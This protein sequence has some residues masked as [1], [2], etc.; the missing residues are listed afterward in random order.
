MAEKG[1][2][3][4]YRDRL[5]KTLSC[6]DLVSKEVLKR[7]VR[8]QILSSSS[9][10]TPQ[11]FIDNVVERRSNELVHTLGMLRSA[12]LAEGGDSNPSNVSHGG[13]K[14]KQDAEELRVMYREGPEGTPFHIL[15]VEGFVDGPVDV[16]LCISW[17][18]DLYKK[19]WPQTTVPNFKVAYSKCL[20]KV[21]IGEHISVVRMKLPWPL[22]TREALINFFEF[23]YFQDGLVVV[24]F[25]S[26][27]DIE[28][29]G[30]YGSHGL[31]RD[32]GLDA[33]DDVVRIDVVG[34]FA[35]QKVTAN[36]SYFRTIANMDIKLDFVPPT[37]I[38]FFSRQLIGSGFKLY[39]KEVASVSRGDEDFSNALKDPMYNRIREALY[40]HDKSNGHKNNYNQTNVTNEHEFPEKVQHCAVHSPSENSVTRDEKICGEIEEIVGEDNEEAGTVNMDSQKHDSPLKNQIRKEDPIAENSIGVS[41][42]VQRA[43]AKLEMA[44]SFIRNSYATSPASR[45][46]SI[47][48]SPMKDETEDSK[49]LG[50]V[51]QTLEKNDVETTAEITSKELTEITASHEHMISS[52]DHTSRD[53]SSSLCTKE[54]SHNSKA[55][56]SP[57]PCISD[58]HSIGDQEVAG[59]I[60]EDI[61]FKDNNSKATDLNSIIKEGRFGKRKTSKHR[62]CC[63]NLLSRQHIST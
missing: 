53:T 20:Q 31:S 21:R 55:P 33:D 36:R 43:L 16:C 11:E 6:H 17:E 23:D 1:N 34:G 62:Y 18:V 57:D 60:L 61:L 37:L 50:S 2:I 5:D 28:N 14:V 51:L 22:S 56:V 44:I 4:E 54:T 32:G 7:L 48:N 38:N 25:N 30:D 24:L 27:S 13:W 49:S 42:E 35:M 29:V 15:L 3:S 41:P 59:T 26:I 45:T 40:S 19:W 52:S 46:T 39:K 12:S 8:N 47:E 63:C 10:E 9:F 58:S